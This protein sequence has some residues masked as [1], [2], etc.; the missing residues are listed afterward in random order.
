MLTLG[1]CVRQRQSRRVGRRAGHSR[2]S[3]LAKEIGRTQLAAEKVL[4]RCR[5]TAGRPAASI[6]PVG[7]ACQWVEYAPA[8][9]HNLAH[10][11]SKFERKARS[12]SQR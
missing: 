10:R 8:S 5:V 3:G 11:V 9:L 2:R 7:S 12:E 4:N 1:Q 6:C